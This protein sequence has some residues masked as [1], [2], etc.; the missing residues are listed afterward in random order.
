MVV[1]HQTMLLL[2]LR[3]IFDERNVQHIECNFDTV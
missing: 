2:I 1:T 3:E